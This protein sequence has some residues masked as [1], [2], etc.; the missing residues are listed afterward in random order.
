MLWRNA[1]AILRRHVVRPDGTC[2]W[3]GH[4]APCTPRTLAERA[5]VVARLPA[6]PAPARAIRNDS[7]RYDSTKLL[8]LLT[9]DSGLIPSGGRSRNSRH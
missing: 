3:C 8:P 6:H 4:R 7:T 5:D 9:A 2:Q 1:Q